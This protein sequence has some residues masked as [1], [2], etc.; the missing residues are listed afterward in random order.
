[1]SKCFNWFPI[2]G[3]GEPKLYHQSDCFTRKWEGCKENVKYWDEGNN[4]YD[5]NPKSHLNKL[6]NSGGFS[7][8]MMGL[9][10]WGVYCFMYSPFTNFPLMFPFLSY[11]LPLNSLPF[12]HSPTK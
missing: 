7:Q 3:L 9:V 5:K 10:L 11:F 1:M 4:E 8:E 12:F 6:N 2:S